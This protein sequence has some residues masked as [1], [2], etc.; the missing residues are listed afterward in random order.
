MIKLYW[1]KKN[2][3]MNKNKFQKEKLMKIIK[4]NK[5]K[6]KKLKLMKI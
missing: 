2:Y 4:I 5:N 3:K 6:F 1:N